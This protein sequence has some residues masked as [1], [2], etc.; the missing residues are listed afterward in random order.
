MMS[1]LAHFDDHKKGTF[2]SFQTEYLPTDNIIV[3]V[4]MNLAKE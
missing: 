3:V 1:F 4:Y 2:R